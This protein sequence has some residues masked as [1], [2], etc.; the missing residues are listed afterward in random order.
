MI[1]ASLVWH[2]VKIVTATFTE[3]AD[4]P[5]ISW[6]IGRVG[7]INRDYITRFYGHCRP[8]TIICEDEHVDADPHALG[9][10]RPAGNLDD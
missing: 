3:V 4:A 9:R 8:G 7:R 6:L 5:S 2:L 10:A 1:S